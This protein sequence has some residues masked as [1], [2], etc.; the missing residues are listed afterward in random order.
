MRLFLLLLILPYL[1]FGQ[2]SDATKIEIGERISFF[3]KTLNENRELLIYSPKS[4][5]KSNSTYPVIFLFDAE[6]L[7]NTVV[8]TL[9]FMNY[10][11]SLPQMPEAYIVGIVNKNRSR[12]MPTPQDFSSSREVQKFNDFISK[13]LLPF[14]SKKLKSSGM[15]ILIGHSQGALFATYLAIQNPTMFQFTLALDVPM[16]VSKTLETDFSNK[17]SHNCN[18]KYIS[19]KAIYGWDSDIQHQCNNHRQISII[20]ESHETMPL[21]GVYEGLKI[22]FEDYL[23]KDKDLPLEKIKNYYAGLSAKYQINYSMPALILLES[24]KQH[25]GQSDKKE[26]LDLLLTHDK[27]YG[28]NEKSMRLRKDVDAITTGPDERVTEAINHASPSANE[29]TPFLGKWSGR[30]KVP[31]GE[32]MLIDFEIKHLNNK[33]VMQ[34]TIMNSFKINSDFLF[35]NEKKQLV[36][37]RKHDGGGVYYSIGDLVNDGRKLIGT[38]DLI[39]FVFPKEMPKFIINT[40]EFIKQ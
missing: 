12:D 28:A 1:A 9:C 2:K 27:M 22:L 29:I 13:E 34:S 14:I 10:S 5:E 15:N 6:S 19:V 3:S 35:V 40:F 17:L 18:Q 36:W 26:A 8:G 20:N 24:A 23:P 38:E 7:F 39:G 25:I 37:G 16:S 30:V 31:N 21:K 32:D 4:A 11:S 33:Y